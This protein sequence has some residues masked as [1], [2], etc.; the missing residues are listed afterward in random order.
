MND[1]L[2]SH[3]RAPRPLAAVFLVLALSL[4]LAAAPALPG[5]PAGA[6]QA[7]TTEA[8]L[9][10]VQRAG[11]LY[12]WTEANPANGMV[13]DR[14]TPG[15]VSSIASTG[16][17]LSALCIGV[18]HGWLPRAAVR[19]RVLTTLNTFWTGPQGNAVNGMI[20]YK[21]LFYHWLDMNTAR[22]TWNAELSTI[23]TA[24]LM[25][26]ILDAKQYFTGN[27]PEEMQIRALADS[28]W[29]RCDWNWTRNNTG[30]I[31]MGWLPGAATEAAGFNTF[32][33]WIGY[34]EAMILY[35][36]AI[37]SPTHP[38][39]GGLWGTWLGGYQWQ[40][41]YGYSYVIF[42][43]LFG[44]QYSH[45]W[46]DFRGIAD[47]YMRARGITYFENSRRATLAQRAY[48]IDNPNNW[49]AYSDSLWGFTASDDPAG[50]KAHGAPPPWD[51]NGTI[52]PTAGL[53][54]LPFAPE[55]VVPLLHNLWN[56]W[57]GTLWGPYGFTDAF[58]PTVG[59][60]GADVL[61]IDQG[62]IVLM[63]ENHRNE[64]VWQRMSRDGDLARGLTLAGFQGRTTGVEP[65]PAPGATL[66]ARAEPNPF[67]AS[68][69]V[70]YHLPAAGHVRVE[71]VDVR[72][73][74]VARLVDGER[75]AGE[76][77]VAVAGADLVPGVY[78][79]RVSTD[80]ASAITRLVRV[81]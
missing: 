21:G 16:F 36:M 48:A 59:W 46:I 38:I 22:R 27:D 43:P 7:Q 14:N 23:D 51:E 79:V 13:R 60:V 31:K 15:A 66:S 34:N 55:V 52:T 64:G 50:Y 33:Q 19:T 71:L 32:G 37:G 67:Q 63:I 2:R 72:G 76:H 24:L 40:T 61:G 45:C 62:P 73:R 78:H 1:I 77:A 25:A 54:S 11:V 12:F 80:G 56:N 17:G 30:A 57:R 28:I 26:G 41:H 29:R 58:N 65:G 42:P 81:R 35:I 6:A 4:G 39:G 53:S 68:A 8:L 3:P 10:T 18:D 49:V 20:G 44:H 5:S 70:R 9:D 69:T 47:G 74:V 75:P